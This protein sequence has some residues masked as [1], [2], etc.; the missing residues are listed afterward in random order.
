MSRFTKILI[1]LTLLI[2]AGNGGAQV[3]ENVGQI[4]RIYNLWDY[5]Q[6][7]V[8]QDDYAYIAA[9]YSG[10]QIIDIS[11]PEHPEVTGYWDDNP[12]MSK[13]VAVSGSFAYVAEH[14]SDLR[15]IDVSD[16]QHPEEVGYISTPG[17]AD[18]VIVSGSY[19]YVAD[20]TSGLRIIDVSDPRQAEYVGSCDTPGLARDVAVSGNFAY[21][22][23]YNNGLRIIDISD[24]QNPEETGYYDTPGNAVG[25]AVSG[26][27]AYVA[28]CPRGLRIIDIS[29]PQHP[30]EVGYYERQAGCVAVNGDLAYVGGFGFRIIDVS[31]PQHPEEVGYYEEWRAGCIAVN[32]DLA[33]IG[34]SSLKIIDVSDPENPEEAGYYDIPGKAYDV[35]VNGNFAYV[36]DLEEGLRIIDVSDPQ[37]PEEV[38]H[39]DTPGEAYGVGVDGDFAYMA[40]YESGLRIIDI[41]DLQNPEE[42]GYYD[43][44]GSAY[45]VVVN[46]DFAY[47]ADYYSLRVIDVS[48]PQHPVE[49]GYYEGYAIIS[50][51]VNG[52]FAYLAASGNGLRIIDVSDPEN[53]EEVGQCDTP[54]EAEG[55][56][57]VSAFAYIADRYSGLRII[58]ISD[59]QH[60]EEV[61]YYSRGWWAYGVAVN[62]DFAY[63]A[64]E[65][66]GLRVID[67]SDPEHPEE[68]GY[69][70]TPGKAED[71]FVSNSLIYVADYTNMGIY[72]FLRDEPPD[73]DWQITLT[74]S[75]G[76]HN[77]N[78]NYAGGAEEA[79][80]GFDAGYDTPEPPHSPDDY[81]SLYFPHED[82]E[83]ELYENFT[84]DVVPADA[85][86]EDAIVWSFEVDTDQ[87]DQ[88]VTLTFDPLDIPDEGLALYI[89]DVETEETI[90]LWEEDSYEYNSGEGGV[91]QFHLV[92]GDEMP[93]DVT[94]IEPNGGEIFEF[95]ENVEIAW[96]ADDRIGVVSSIV[97]YSLDRGEIWVEIGQTEGGDCTID[98][99]VPD[100]YSAYCLIKVEC[101][102]NMD[103]AGEDDSDEYFG[104]TPAELAEEFGAGWN[105]ISVPLIG[106][107]GSLEELFDDDIDNFYH[108]F[109]FHPD[110]GF[111]VVDEV[112]LGA[113]YWLATL[114][115]VTLN[116]AAAA[117]MEP[118][119]LDLAV[120]WNLIGAPFPQ[121]IPGDSLCI[122]TGD[123]TYT[124]EE[125]IEEELVQG[126]FYS[127]DNAEAAYDEDDALQ[128]WRGHW[129][130]ALTGDL[131][132]VISPVT[133]G[134]GQRMPA[135]DEEPLP[136]HWRLR[137]DA[138]MEGAADLITTLGSTEEATDQFDAEYDLPEPPVPP[139][140]NYVSVYF[141]QE[142]WDNVFG[143]RFN[144]D[145]RRTM[146]IDEVFEWKMVVVSGEEGNVTLSWDDIGGSVP[147]AYS[148]ILFDRETDA[149]I[150]L[151]NEEDYTYFSDGDREFDIIVT[152]GVFRE[153][154]ISF[155][156]G[157]NLISLNLVPV[158]DYWGEMNSD[159][160]PL[161]RL[162]LTDFF[163]DDGRPLFTMMRDERGQFCAPAWNFYGIEYWNLTEGYHFRV[164]EEFEVSWQGLAIHPQTELE[165]ETGWNII[166]YYP[167]YDL[168]A[169][170][171]SDYYVIS[172][173]MDNV[174]MAK[175]GQ[176]HFLVPEWGYSNM[177]PW[178]PGLGYQINVDEDVVLVYPEEP[179]ERTAMAVKPNGSPVSPKPGKT[180]YNPGFGETG[181]R[182]TPTGENM[183][184]LVTSISG[185]EIADGA[186][187]AAF[188]SSGNLIGVGMFTDGKC[189]LAI[190]GDDK[191]TD[192]VVEGLREGETFS[193]KLWDASD[194]CDKN[195]TVSC[196]KQGT[197]LIYGK[198][199]FLVLDA[200]AV[201]PIPD[202]F[203]L[204]NAYPNP[205]NAVT[206]ISYGLPNAS[207]I[208][209]HIYDIS[210][211]LITTLYNNHRE[212]GHYKV[213][214]NAETAA[215]GI[216]CVQMEADGFRYVR[217]VVLVK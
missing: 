92:Y 69:Y 181:L 22:A 73:P 119:T 183:S 85:Y 13:G 215:A 142:N 124:L 151:M 128:S 121:E 177:E 54:G 114:D 135:D 90:N 176:G 166:A 196:I 161:V 171:G 51:A 24:L 100:S 106:E 1:A 57:V 5:G 89:E 179:E 41:S 172:P 94:V 91:R 137:I 165:I 195:L 26:N 149:S 80:F 131:Q 155:H 139:N 25:V 21:I 93:P 125:A 4:G 68:V 53:P 79:S 123:E 103:N 112:S 77:D 78:N 152:A 138:R 214:W 47:V 67:V 130:R 32:G 200:V 113:G 7:I 45:D 144:C 46:G 108:V 11:N 178:T 81:I 132:L 9:G 160:G 148:F 150:E 20:G 212:A 153:N 102:D 208:T 202:E 122:V 96:E 83:H 43:T 31:D 120:G 82:Y 12:L 213:V 74:A 42:V 115:D 38:G 52:D 27:F 182:V 126:V 134:G 141:D 162:M 175:D 157:W 48:D 98:W 70:R 206:T 39:Y 185:V 136:E 199:G 184:V 129:F 116:I 190:W 189:G 62:G 205:F 72:R 84:T 197:G 194:D 201:P 105:L 2:A 187:I 40:D 95:G 117:R 186:Q 118:L 133:E 143:R 76:D 164:Y 30:E 127:Y 163:D 33:Y 17:Q 63:V 65:G 23:D 107:D 217:K 56:A 204:S 173:I 203:Y 60:P 3:R 158:E 44:P 216:Y 97:S 58:D 66:S 50:V 8:V 147:E 28:D 59:P 10:L 6:D 145:I 101:S 34:G 109:S 174:I 19:L 61:G 209:L 191:Y 29:D 168:P 75:V 146:Q 35:A 170:R 88:T 37:H 198:D 110:D 140:R 15:I 207:N 64:C 14:C 49:V 36:A 87:E 55:V 210:G 86:I 104:I 193:L 156:E 111:D 167:D 211:R 18:G 192:D 188:G 16:A 71:V 154:V 180:I 99:E 169:D 159:P